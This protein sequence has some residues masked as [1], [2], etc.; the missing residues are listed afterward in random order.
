MTTEPRKP[1]PVRLT[2]ELVF[3]DEVM[4]TMSSWLGVDNVTDVFHIPEGC[5]VIPDSAIAPWNNPED[6]VSHET[7]QT[8]EEIVNVYF[9]TLFFLISVPTSVINMA[10]FWKHGIKE[11]INLCLFCLSFDDLIVVAFHFQMKAEFIYATISETVYKGVARSFIVN[12]MIHSLAGFVY[13]SGFLSTLIA[14]ER[15]LCVVKPLKAQSMIKTK[16]TVVI[17]AIGHVLI[18]AGHYVIA[19]RFSTVC[20]FDPLTGQSVEA[21]YSSKFYINNKALVDIFV[22]II[23]G[24]SLP[25]IYFAGITVSTIVT[26]LKLRQMAEWRELSST[27]TLSGVSAVKDVTLT[28]MLIGTSCVFVAS[29]TPFFLF[30]AVQPFV[31]ELSLN[32]KYYN[33]YSLFISIQQLCVYFNSSVNFFVYYY[34]GTR[35]RLTVRRMIFG[36]RSTYNSAKKLSVA[37]R[38]TAVSSVGKSEVTVTEER[39]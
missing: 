24:F 3:N 36:C 31:P 14:L 27:A 35:F 8:F 15:G 1:S 33:T 20:T 5:F 2:T 18:M 4:N 6:L 17:I 19:A 32:G 29:N 11:R 28:R 9:L 34:L 10:V 30:H 16:T 21:I 22:G 26:V 39:R 12:N 13:T 25:V 7:F 23:F 38:F 37:E